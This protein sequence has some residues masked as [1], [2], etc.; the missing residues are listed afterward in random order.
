MELKVIEEGKDK[1]KIEVK[2][3]GHTF[4]NLIRD[5]LWN[6]KSVEAAGYNVEH[7]LVSEPRLLVHGSSPI[8]SLQNAVE[9]LRKKNDEFRSSLKELKLKA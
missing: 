7:A 6:D 5:E 4:C 8:K 3:E 9:R 1:L 2:M